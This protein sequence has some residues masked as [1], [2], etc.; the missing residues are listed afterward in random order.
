MLDRHSSRCRAQKCSDLHV[1]IVRKAPKSTNCRT[2]GAVIEV[3]QAR[4]DAS[5]RAMDQAIK[6][7]GG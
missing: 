7:A 4:S 2:C 1:Y 6:D 3:E 5:K